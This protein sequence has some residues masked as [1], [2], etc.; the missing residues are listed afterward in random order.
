MPRAQISGSFDPEP[1]FSGLLPPLLG[2]GDYFRFVHGG[3]FR[4]EGDEVVFGRGG[5]DGSDPAGD[6]GAREDEPGGYLGNGNT[7][8]TVLRYLYVWATLVI[9]KNNDVS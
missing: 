8:S 3:H 4:F 5:E 6:G 1:R 7:L 9:E 2:V